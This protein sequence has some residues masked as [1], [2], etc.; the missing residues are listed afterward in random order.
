MSTL[1]R[2]TALALLALAG[3]AQSQQQPPT[4]SKG[5]D[6]K[7][8]VLLDLGP[9]IEGLAGRDLRM[10]HVTLAVGATVAIHGHK[11]RP[12]IDYILQ[13]TVLEYRNGTVK[14]YGPGEFALSDKN[15]T[16]AWENNGT[17]PVLILSIDIVKQ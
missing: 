17:V 16:H 3:A 9:E 8:M 7:P 15:T 1:H 5:I 11:D 6:N 2:L 14:Q 13:G 12:A 4:Q 10:R